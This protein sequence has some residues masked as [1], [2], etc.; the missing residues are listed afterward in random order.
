M[1][2]TFYVFR[3]VLA[4]EEAYSCRKLDRGM[5]L[6]E[7]T[8]IF[9]FSRVV[10]VLI[11]PIA[12]TRMTGLWDKVQAA[13]RPG[14]T[15]L[16]IPITLPPSL[17][18]FHLVQVNGNAVEGS[19]YVIATPPCSNSPCT[20]CKIV[21]RKN[22]V[23]YSLNSLVSLYNIFLHSFKSWVTTSHLHT[24]VSLACPWNERVFKKWPRP[25]E[26]ASSFFL[27]LDEG[28]RR[29]IKWRVRRMGSCVVW[30]MDGNKEK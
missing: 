20:I 30:P 15:I 5:H 2:I 3:V 27:F 8:I 14:V 12:I 18:S 24:G 1:K 23:F 7:I 29:E 16:F 11:F 4:L 21:R 28:D 6:K 25:L 10:F 19:S 13:R 17:L 26:T 22:K 9:L